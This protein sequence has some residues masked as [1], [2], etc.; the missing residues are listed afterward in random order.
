MIDQYSFG[1]ITIQNKTYTSDLKIINGHVPPDWWR[2]SGHSV[3][4]DDIQDILNA[5]PDVIVIGSGSSGLMKIGE[6]LRER[7][8]FDG[9]EI[10]AEPTSKAI[11]TF[12]QMVADGGNVAGGFHLTC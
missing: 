11:E 5:E 6:Q 7:C 2:K 12:N 4:I 10:I 3:G 8:K 1:T 9:I